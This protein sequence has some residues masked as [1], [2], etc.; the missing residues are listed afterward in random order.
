VDCCRTQQQRQRL[1]HGIFEPSAH[2]ISTPSTLRL[3]LC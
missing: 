1:V 3:C 2:R